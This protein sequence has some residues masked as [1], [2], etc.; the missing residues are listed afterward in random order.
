MVKLP[1]ENRVEYWMSLPDSKYTK[2]FD[3]G[4]LPPKTTDELMQQIQTPLE[5]NPY[6]PFIPSGG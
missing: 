4:I 6:T 2:S 5:G 3:W 1:G